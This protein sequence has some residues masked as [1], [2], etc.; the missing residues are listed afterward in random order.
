MTSKDARTTEVE[1]RKQAQEH[2]GDVIAGSGERLEPRKLDQMVSLRL[3]PD[4]A[5]AL[6]D[7]ADVSGASVSDLLRRGALLLLE[8]SQSVPYRLS[9]EVEVA[10]PS[11][12][13]QVGHVALMSPPLTQS[14]LRTEKSGAGRSV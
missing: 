11:Q 7:L 1:R 8:R 4:L 9:Y 13:M 6:R 3:D 10:A 12:G 14:G 5:A 2:R